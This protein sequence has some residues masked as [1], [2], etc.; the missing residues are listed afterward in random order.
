MSADGWDVA[1]DGM[2]FLECPRWHDGRLYMSDF[3]MRAVFTLESNGTAAKVVDVPNRPGGIGWLPDGRMLVASQLDRRV[4]RLEPDG[5]LVE[6]ADLSSLVNGPVNDM[7]VAGSG[8][9]YIGNF[10][11]DALR[12]APL[13]AAPVVAIAPD[14]TAQIATEPLLFPNGAVVTPDESTL[15]VAETMGNRLSAFDIRQDGSLGPRRSWAVFSP[16]PPVEMDKPVSD[17]LPSILHSDFVTAD[18]IAIDSELGIWAADPYHKRVCRV[19]AAGAVAET[20]STGDDMPFAVALGGP[21]RSTL[22]ACV[23]PNPTEE[24]R[25]STTLGRL[26]RRKVNVP[27]PDRA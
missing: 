23:A 10:G 3:Y 24:E 15:I 26:L 17:A 16:Q 21:D 22:F 9:A 8:F 14:G 11:S 6:Y 12:G 2:R 18:G 27:G 19:S 13:A 4:M 25:E 5:R 1:L 20:L 7:V